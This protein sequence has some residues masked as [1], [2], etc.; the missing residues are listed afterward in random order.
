MKEFGGA[1]LSAER[2]SSHLK[3]G[4]HFRGGRR[5]K[6]CTLEIRG[7]KMRITPQQKAVQMLEKAGPSCS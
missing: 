6:Q 7:V 2:G 3:V 4:K 5:L 1:A